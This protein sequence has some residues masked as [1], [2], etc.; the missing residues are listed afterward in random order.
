MISATDA[1]A[2]LKAVGD[3]QNVTLMKSKSMYGDPHNISKVIQYRVDI[4]DEEGNPVLY[5]VLFVEIGGVY[6]ILS[7]IDQF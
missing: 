5:E 2:K 1:A 4:V 7:V 6:K 3:A